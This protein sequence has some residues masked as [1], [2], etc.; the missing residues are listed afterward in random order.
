MPFADSDTL[1]D[2]DETWTYQATGSALAGQYVNT[3]SVTGSP[4]AGPDVSA[5][6][7]SH[8]FGMA[9]AIDIEKATNGEDADSPTGPTLNVG[10]SVTW[11]YVVTNPGNVELSDIVV[12][13]D[14]GVAVNNAGDG[15]GF[16]GAG[17]GGDHEG[18][19]QAGERHQ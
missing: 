19:G 6:D 17:E 1:L 13:D 5:S 10:D 15:G 7:P 11:T 14:Q 12:T 9:A 2:T 3:G 16:G 8:Y 4:P 18:Q